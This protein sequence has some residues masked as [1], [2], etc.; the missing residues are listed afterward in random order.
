[1]LSYTAEGYLFLLF[2]VLLLCSCGDIYLPSPF[3]GFLNIIYVHN[4]GCDHVNLEGVSDS[5]IAGTY[6]IC[7]EYTRPW[8]HSSFWIAFFHGI[9]AKK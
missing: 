3:K 9:F 8:L 7:Q 4:F 6:C 1:M 5:I 2:L